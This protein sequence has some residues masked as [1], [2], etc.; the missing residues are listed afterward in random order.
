MSQD[1]NLH[2]I[3]D[4]SLI[5]Q[6]RKL[7]I[8]KIGK[9]LYDCPT[10]DTWASYQEQVHDLVSIGVKY[11]C[12]VAIESKWEN[13]PKLNLYDHATLIENF[14]IQMVQA[15]EHEDLPLL[16]ETQDKL[17]EFLDSFFKVE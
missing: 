17:D 14:L 16:K 6:D 9:A 4:I 3:E 15:L 13:I 2:E 8:K 10:Q 12:N 11:W 1:K 5:I 7:K